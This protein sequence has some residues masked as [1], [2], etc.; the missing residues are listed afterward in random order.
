MS[1]PRICKPHVAVKHNHINQV[2]GEN[3]NHNSR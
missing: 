3:F 2:S 1:S